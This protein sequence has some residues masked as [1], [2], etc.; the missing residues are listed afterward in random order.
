M[1]GSMSTSQLKTGSD[2]L[3]NA[4]SLASQ[5]KGKKRER[6]E[7]SS[8]PVKRERLAKMG[9]GD[10]GRYSSESSLKLEIAKVVEKGPLVDTEGVDKLVHVMLIEINER[11]IDLT[12]RTML[13]NVIVGTEKP[14]CLSRFVQIRG[15]SILDDW[16]QDVHK[17]KTDDS[18]GVKHNDKLAEEF[19]L[20]LLRALD[21]L[22]VNLPALQMCNIGKLVNHLR[23]HKKLEIQKKARS[24]VD[25]WKRRVEA[26]MNM[27]DAKMGSVPFKSLDSTSVGPLAPEATSSA[28]L[29]R[30]KSFEETGKSLLVKDTGTLKRKQ[31]AVIPYVFGEDTTFRM[32]FHAAAINVSG[33][34]EEELDGLSGNRHRV[35]ES[36]TRYRI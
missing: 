24:L 9:D 22:P 31:D 13:T 3:Q 14:D 8:D 12:A 27:N 28:G 7:Q 29:E 36:Q 18:S 25:T 30:V 32:H 34:I 26:E 17:G 2:G 10:S 19:L 11:K 33:F 5:G 21:K 16:L 20:V 35:S 23:T 15:L 6:V 1:T 4:A